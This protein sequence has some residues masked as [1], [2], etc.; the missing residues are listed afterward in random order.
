MEDD[1]KRMKKLPRK[2]EYFLVVV[3]ATMGLKNINEHVFPHPIYT[4]AIMSVHFKI[5]DEVLRIVFLLPHPGIL[6][7]LGQDIACIMRSFSLVSALIFIVASLM[8][9]NPGPGFDVRD[10]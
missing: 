3:G 7:Y 5:V 1:I 4:C 6:N 9:K 8:P 10:L 2:L